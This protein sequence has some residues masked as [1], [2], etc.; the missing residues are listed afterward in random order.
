MPEGVVVLAYGG[1]HFRLYATLAINDRGV[2]VAG[3]VWP[4]IGLF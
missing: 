4:A 3:H 1:A 2:D